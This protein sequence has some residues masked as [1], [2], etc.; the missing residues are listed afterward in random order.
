M[1]TAPSGTIAG[2]VEVE[3]V[4][5]QPGAGHAPAATSTVKPSTNKSLAS[6]P[7]AQERDLVWRRYANGWSLAL[8]RVFRDPGLPSL[9]WGDD[10]E[11]DHDPKLVFVTPSVRSGFGSELD[12]VEATGDVV[13]HRFLGQGFADVP[14]GGGI[15]TYVPGWTEQHGPEDAYDQTL[16]GYS[17][18]AW[19][20]F[21]EQYVP[22][23]SALLQH[24]GAFWDNQAVAAR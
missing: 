15:V 5:L 21:S 11:R 10:I 8:V 12:L 6:R 22:D 2:V 9:V 14:P 13:L 1:V 7:G 20:V 19:R 17:S 3:T 18:K 24:R 16:I 4:P 23:A